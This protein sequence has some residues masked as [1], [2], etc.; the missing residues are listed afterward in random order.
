M[1][2]DE[3]VVVIDRRG[4]ALEIEARSE[5]LDVFYLLPPAEQ[6]RQNR[7]AKILGIDVETLIARRIAYFR[8][9]IAA[10]VVKKLPRRRS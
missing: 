3:R 8:R 7:V 1:T 2:T 4:H 10:G 6:E 9:Q 5:A